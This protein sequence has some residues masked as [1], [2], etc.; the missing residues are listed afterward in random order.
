V[1]LPLAIIL[2]WLVLTTCVGI[3]AGVRRKF[4]MEEYFV[5]GRSFGTVLFYTIAAAEI[6]SAFAF[7]GLAGWAYGKGMS[8]VYALAYGSIAYGLYFF[9]GPRINRLGRRAGYLTQPDFFEDRWGSKALGVVAAITGVVFIVPYLQLQLMGAG[10]IVQIA[11]G[12]AIGWRVAVLLAVLAIVAFVYVSGLRGIGWTNLLQAVIMLGGMFAVGVL[13][14]QRFFGGLEPM[15]ET[16]ERLAPAHL[17]LPDSA[18]LGLSWYTSTALLC[19][20]AMWIWPHV[21]AATYSARSER[22]VRRNAGILPL[23]Q[24]AMIPVIIVGFTCAAKAAADPQFAARIEKPDHAMLIALVDHFPR[25]AAGLI[26]AGGLAASI[27]TASA[28]ILTA[29]N[30]LARNVVRKLKP[31]G[32][33]EERAA[34]LGRWLVPVVT[35]FALLFAFL[36]PEMLVS[37][38]LTGFSGIGQFL[39]AVLLGLFARWPTRA[40]IFSGLLVGLG[41]VVGCHLADAALPL[42]VHPGFLGLICNVA[43]VGLVSVFTKK[44]GDERLQRFAELLTPPGRVD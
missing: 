39:P 18:G 24:L 6:Y 21:F 40:G 31:G 20:L 30:L 43:T 8:I 42:G 16:L 19:G 1:T 17:T 36:A 12:G 7:L 2:G 33:A 44:I 27:S 25:W 35:G 9:I 22:V 29:A 41:V 34:R 5:G 3:L 26:G 15:F 28:L 23:Y 37:L 13:F 10:M 38:L 32:L 4:S 14:P 11:S